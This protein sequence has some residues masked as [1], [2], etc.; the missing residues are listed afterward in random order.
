MKRKYSFWSL[1]NKNWMRTQVNLANIQVHC[2]VLISNWSHLRIKLRLSS[3]VET[4]RK[5]TKE[6][7]WVS[8]VP[9]LWIV[10]WT[11]SRSSQSR[12]RKILSFNTTGWILSSII[13]KRYSISKLKWTIKSKLKSRYIQRKKRKSN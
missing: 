4:I 7:R 12:S 6:S 3:T 9:F 11:P 13:S 8:K 5:T 1:R 2:K 10:L